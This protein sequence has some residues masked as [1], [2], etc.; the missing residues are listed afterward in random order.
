M[1][2][3]NQLRFDSI[4][5]ALHVTLGAALMGCLDPT[6]AIVD[7][8]TDS[9]CAYGVDT[10]I[11]AGLLTDIEAPNYDTRTSTCKEGGEIGSIVLVPPEDADKDAPFALK[12]VASLGAPLESC[13]AP[14]YGPHCIVARRAMR[15]V[16]QRPFHV[17]VR[18]SQ[19]C[20]G[21][22]CPEKQTCVDGTCRSSTVD[23]NECAGADTCEPDQVDVPPWQLPIV[24]TGL[25]MARDVEVGADGAVVFAG[26]FDTSVK[27]GNETFVSKG[28]SDVF[29][30]AYAPTGAVKWARSFGGPRTDEV[31]RMT[32]GSDGSIIVSFQFEE[33]LDVGGGPM[34]SV[35]LTDIAIAKFTA[36]GKLEWAIPIGGI[37]AEYASSVTTDR[38]GNIYVAGSYDQTFAVQGQTVPSYG[39]TDSFLMSFTRTGALRWAKGIG[40]PQS[41]SAA[42]I[43]TGING[44]MYV[45]GHFAG[46]LK[47]NDTTTVTSGGGTD[48]FLIRYDSSA[49]FQWIR[50]LASN[51]NDDRL[52][53][54]AVNG[55]RVFVTG[56]IGDEGTFAGMPF[57][58]KDGNGIVA[59]LD[60]A[61]TIQWAKSFALSGIGAG[62]DIA[63]AADGAIVI[64]GNTDSGSVFGSKPFPA[65]GYSNAFVAVLE[66]DG[67]SRWA[68]M[69]GSS[70]Y[71]YTVSV[72]AAQNGFVYAAG[73]YA[74]DF[75]NGVDV[76]TGP[77]QFDV[78]GFLLRIAPP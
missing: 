48:A 10:G 49:E 38:F 50:T 5:L 65:P 36:Y 21:V 30:A 1:I 20:A 59:A 13:V 76:W 54:V 52:M 2:D 66:S 24:G 39:A 70:Q 4:G 63:I 18:L 27:I 78:E 12:V 33:S 46:E 69:F 74:N 55:D 25:H 43:A 11:S 40:S 53:E 47:L 35:G 28:G 42:S 34:S 62:Q 16:P 71:S 73:W 17:P 61:G 56:K 64:G 37:G 9:P 77:S 58:R 41:D 14:D 26:L 67:T 6:Q 72:A 32:I 3:M 8:S 15:F 75:D 7:I 19:A 68:K 44:D 60:T 29:L 45:T 31:Y 51:G 22:I 57:D 23:P